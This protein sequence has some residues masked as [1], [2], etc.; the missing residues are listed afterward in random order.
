VDLVH[1]ESANIYLSG[2]GEPKKLEDIEK[3]EP[4]GCKSTGRFI[5]K[6]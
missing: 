5:M 3:V 2:P 4:T 1:A 6:E